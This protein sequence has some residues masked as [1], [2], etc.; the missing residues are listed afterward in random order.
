MRKFTGTDI[1]VIRSMAARGATGN[2]I[3]IALSRTPLGIRT[4]CVELGISLRDPRKRIWH[5]LRI[6]F[7]PTVHKALTLAARKR[8]VGC[9]ELCRRILT[10]VVVHDLIDVILMPGSVQSVEGISSTRERKIAEIKT[11]ILIDRPTLL[12][13]V[14]GQPQ[15]AGCS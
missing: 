7:D 1:Q 8:G 14:A 10:A 9:V 4:K 11:A 3:A 15:L 13:R 5:R 12:G 2:E 6:L